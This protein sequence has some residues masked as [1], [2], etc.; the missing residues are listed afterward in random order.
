M[1]KSGTGVG[2]DLH[3]IPTPVEKGRPI[4]A[5]LDGDE[6]EDGQ[7]APHVGWQ[8]GVTPLDDA[9]CFSKRPPPIDSEC[10]GG[11]CDRGNP[12]VGMDLE[13]ASPWA[14]FAGLGEGYVHGQAASDV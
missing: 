2:L 3:P 11:S 5:L 4:V 12:S 7:V 8:A 14:L 9:D 6:M 1:G 10:K 13:Y